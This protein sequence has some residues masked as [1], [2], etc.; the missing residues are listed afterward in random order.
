MSDTTYLEVQLS[1][2]K[3]KTESPTGVLKVVIENRDMINTE[4]AH[5]EL[6]DLLIKWAKS[7][8]RHPGT[9]AVTITPGQ[10]FQGG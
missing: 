3:S 7:W 10:E 8:L 2:A 6:C 9:E 4:Q 1:S 5:R